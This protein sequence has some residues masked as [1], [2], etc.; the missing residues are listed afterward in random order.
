M[1]GVRFY[2]IIII[3]LFFSLLAGHAGGDSRL[4]CFYFYPWYS[5]DSRHWGDSPQTPVVDVP[6]PGYY[7]SRDPMVIDWQLGLMGEAG[8]D[9]LLVSWWGPGSFEDY[10]ARLLFQRLGDHG[11]KAAILVEPYLGGDPG[12]YGEVWWRETLD[13][14][15][16]NFVEKYPESYL[17]WEGRPLVLAFNPIG[18]S[19]RPLDPRFTIRIVGNDIDRAGYQDWD[20]W[21]DYLS[22]WVSEKDVELKVRSDGYVAITPRF[23]D[24]VFCE[25]GVRTGCGER[26]IDPDYSLQ[27]YATQWEWVLNNLDKVRLVAV[28]SWNEYHERSMVEP[29][30]DA[31]A[32]NSDPYYLY[33][34]T[35]DYTSRLEAGGGDRGV[36]S[37]LV[38]GALALAALLTLALI[39]GRGWMRR[40]VGG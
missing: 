7:D 14:I 12:L 1:A 27:A 29:H 37:L 13:Y 8:I 22:P 23:D 31:T 26:L 34:L 25:A 4:V 18:M 21:P 9:C 40:G 28:Y 11:L 17:A 3:S 39:V 15:Y 19:Y 35:M 5:G 20:L 33:K 2:V 24:R 30:V 10:A 32:V 16:E 38:P 36:R 6:L